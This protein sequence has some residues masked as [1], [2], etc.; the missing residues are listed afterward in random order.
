MGCR[1]WSQSWRVRQEELSLQTRGSRRSLS[2][3]TLRSKEQVKF[4]RLLPSLKAFQ[5]RFLWCE[6]HASVK[7]AT[8]QKEKLQKFEVV[9]PNVGVY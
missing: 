7:C 1:D 5:A 3:G 6:L 2:L 8:Y 9:L 4:A